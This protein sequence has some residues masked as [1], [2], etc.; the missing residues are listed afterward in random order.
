MQ[1]TARNFNNFFYFYLID[2]EK[3]YNEGAEQI[4][5][6]FNYINKKQGLKDILDLCCGIGRHSIPIASK[7][8]ND[9]GIDTNN[10][11][12]NFAKEKT[13]ELGIKNIKF[14]TKDIRKL[15]YNNKFDMVLCLFNSFGYFLHEENLKLLG[16]IHTSLKLGGYFILET[17]IKT[18]NLI[19]KFPISMEFKHKKYT[20]KFIQ[21]FIKDKSIIK[22]ISSLYKNDKKVKEAKLYIRL[23]SYSEIEIMLKKT[24]FKIINEFENYNGLKFQK[25]RSAS[26]LLFSKKDDKKIKVFDI[27]D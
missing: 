2:L 19:K 15:S 21:Y 7:G 1:L 8:Y 27:G 20:I 14:F 17:K 12:I 9:I 25:N 13:K 23:Y 22:T 24:G 4:D 3:H 16:E 26:L 6:I 10:Q 5:F 18:E 11:F